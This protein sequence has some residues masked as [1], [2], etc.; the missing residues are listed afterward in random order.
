VEAFFEL[1]FFDDLDNE[2]EVSI[3]RA[4]IFL[5]QAAVA[6]RRLRCAR[7]AHLASE[8][9]LVRFHRRAVDGIDDV[10]DFLQ[11]HL[12]RAFRAARDL[13]APFRV[14]L[15][16]SSADSCLKRF[17]VFFLADHDGIL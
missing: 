15:G 11:V 9:L 7:C 10:Q 2:G 14:R 17:P 12:D 8:R 16:A 1:R 13:A 6:V 3:E 5:P 4:S